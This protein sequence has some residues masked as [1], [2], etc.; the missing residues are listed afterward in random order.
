V[1][2]LAMLLA[3]VAGLILVAVVCAWFAFGVRQARD[4]SRASAIVS[5]ASNLTAAQQQR[6]DALLGAAA[7]LNPDREV[8]LVRGQ[9]A[10][11]AGHYRAARAILERVLSSEP[12]NIEAWVVL[13]Q[14]SPRDVP[15]VETAVRHIALLDPIAAKHG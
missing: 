12:M 1:D 8:D 3:R 6:A 7:T 4:L 13:A 9:A 15:L 14:A 5:S 11:L 2:H 10:I